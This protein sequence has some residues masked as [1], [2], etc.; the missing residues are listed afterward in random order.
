MNHRQSKKGRMKHGEYKACKKSARKSWDNLI[1]ECKKQSGKFE[2]SCFFI[3]KIGGY[4][5]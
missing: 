4:L 5:Y 2:K 3:K 1:K